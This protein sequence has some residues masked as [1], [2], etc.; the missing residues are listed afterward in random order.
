VKPQSIAT[1]L[2]VPAWLFHVQICCD[3]S[4]DRRMFEPIEFKYSNE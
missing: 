3:N 1:N 2:I 4:N